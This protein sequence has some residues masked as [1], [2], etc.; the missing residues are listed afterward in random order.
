MREE[1]NYIDGN[2]VGQRKF[3][4]G[5]HHVPLRLY[6]Q[7]TALSFAGFRLSIHREFIFLFPFVDPLPTLA[8][9]IEL[10]LQSRHA[11]LSS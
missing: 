10:G 3:D 1:V 7:N 6:L 4:P 11:G 8:E 9:A 5:K 2:M